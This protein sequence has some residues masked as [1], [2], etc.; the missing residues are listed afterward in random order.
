MKQR[1]YE[2]G[3]YMNITIENGVAIIPEGTEE[4]CSD[5]IKSLEFSEIIIPYGCKVKYLTFYNNTSLIKATINS[6]DL[7]YAAFDSCVNL[8]E[9]TFT[10]KVTKIDCNAFRDCVSLKKINIQDGVEFIGR[11]AFE[12][13]INLEELVIP[14]SVKEIDNLAFL[15]CT[16]LSKITIKNPNIIT[17]DGV[18]SGCTHI[19]EINIPDTVSGNGLFTNTNVYTLINPSAS[20]Y[21]SNYK[22][23][24]NIYTLNIP[25]GIIEIKHHTFYECKN[26]SSVILPKSLRKIGRNAFAK[27][28]SLESIVIQN[29]L[30]DIEPDCFYECKNLKN[31]TIINGEET[32]RIDVSLLEEKT[33]EN[34][35]KVIDMIRNNYFNVGID[36]MDKVNIMLGRYFYS[37]NTNAFQFIKSNLKKIIAKSIENDVYDIISNI[38][39]STFFTKRT[40]TSILKYITEN[41]SNE[42]KAYEIIN[43]IT[44]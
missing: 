43:N 11:G 23:C 10:N 32:F 33:I 17:G 36:Y 18:F 31:I 27:C 24:N 14:A 25:E 6:D 2:R 21:L 34:F 4:I 12:K 44:F 5:D 20:V 35:G 30:V 42:T 9:V 37:S 19:K 40:Q 29:L 41:Y 28:E 22:Y 7:D 13:C 16:W 26:L 39:N 3:I 15:N 1:K 38:A 8:A